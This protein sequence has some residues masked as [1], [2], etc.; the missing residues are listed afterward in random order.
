MLILELKNNLKNGTFF[1]R[2]VRGARFNRGKNIPNK[3]IISFNIEI[4]PEIKVIAEIQGSGNS[5]YVINIL[6]EIN[7][8]KIIHDCPDFK[9]GN[10]FCKHIVKILFLLDTPTCQSICHHSSRLTFTSDF[11]LVKR[12]KTK[13]YII[14]AD[15]LIQQAKYYEAINFLN[16]AYQESRNLDY[17]FKIG[18]ISLK[19]KFYDEFLKY[20]VIHKG[21]VAKY[22]SGFPKVISSTISELENY[23]FSKKVDI[24]I[25]IKKVLINFPKDLLIS[26]INQSAIN[27][28]DS[29]ILRY[30]MLLDLNLKINIIKYFSDIPKV[31]KSNL[32]SIMESKTIDL[33]SEAIL[34]MESEE[35]I[36]SLI[37]ITTTCKFNSYSAI[38]SKAQE[39]KQ[40]LKEMYREG[41]KSKHAFLRSLVIANTDTDKLRQMKF[42]KKYN[43]NSLVWTSPYKSEIPLHYYILEKCGFERHHLEY[44]NVN[45][46]IE[47]YPVFAEIF[48]GNNPV[49]YD[50]KNFWG[51]FE[52]KIMNI[53]Q[54]KP[55]VELDYEVNFQDLE[56]FMLIEWDLAQKP[57]LGSY[58]C[59]FSDSFIIPDKTHPLTHEIQPFD[60]LLCEKKPIAIKNNN[61][62]IVKPLRRINIKT[63][64]Q[65]VWSGIEYISSYLP[66]KLIEDLKKY[67]IDE[68]DAL[69]NIEDSF[70]RSFLPDKADH[71]KLFFGFIQHKIIKELNNTYLKVITT[72]NYEQKVLRMIGFERY[73]QIFKSNMITQPFKKDSLKRDSLQELKLDLKKF[74]SKK[75]AELIDKKEFASIKLKIL[76]SFPSLKNWTI[77]II[78]ELKSQLE[79]CKIYKNSEKSFDI[80]NLI[81]NYYGR[82]LAKEAVPDKLPKNGNIKGQSLLISD[83]ELSK[84]IENFKYLNLNA[85]KVVEKAG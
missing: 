81:D 82:I 22:L 80:Q 29:S 74:I 85:P 63:A 55:L 27:K 26:T 10:N 64:I 3:N 84:I 53:V 52:P 7:G 2:R 19:Y 62:K 37:K 12:S 73:S 83:V 28:I 6:Q 31:S 68:L 24:L 25:N 44:T 51:N 13:S 18:E 40:K 58:I 14:K 59:Q 9:N 1:Q 65:L 70:N 21:L 36:D 69:D 4:A 39:Y 56:K 72:P 78:S 79:K 8:F 45:N 23:N 47:N 60:L 77:K 71:K 32:K 46:F 20:S 11:S 41:L 48:S 34:N 35:E 54:N 67:K 49:R 5:R 33:V 57:I 30:V 50:V 61:I 38:Y 17:I 42:V 66:L 76:K 75:L 15:D 16:Q 43:Y